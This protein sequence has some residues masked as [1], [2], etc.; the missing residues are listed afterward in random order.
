MG[1]ATEMVFKLSFGSIEMT[2]K[3]FREVEGVIEGAVKIGIVGKDGWFIGLTP[4][5]RSETIT[6]ITKMAVMAIIILFFIG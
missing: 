2:S 3:E 6:K 5:K 4:Q 1:V